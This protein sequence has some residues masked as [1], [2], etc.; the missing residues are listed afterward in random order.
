LLQSLA[1]VLSK[2]DHPRFGVYN[3]PTRLYT[4]WCKGDYDLIRKV[5][6]GNL[7]KAGGWFEKEKEEFRGLLGDVVDLDSPPTSSE[8]VREDDEFFESR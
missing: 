2:S 8:D 1:E 5:I 4:T 7:C 3:R 6:R